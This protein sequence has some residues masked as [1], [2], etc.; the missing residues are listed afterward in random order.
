VTRVLILLVAAKLLFHAWYVPAWEGPDEPFHLARV[1]G[2]DFVSAN[3]VHSIQTHPCAS[4]LHRAVGCSPFGSEAGGKPQPLQVRN[5]EAHQPPL[6]YAIGRVWIA[7]FNDPLSQLCAM[8]LFSSLLVIAAIVVFL[9]PIG[10]GWLDAALLAMLVPGAAEALARCANDAG[11]FAWSAAAMWAISRKVRTAFI[12]VLAM[13]GPLVKLTALVVVA[14]LIAW[15]YENRD[16]IHAILIASLSMLFIPLQQTRGYRFGGTVEL[17]AAAASTHDSLSQWV[18]GF[19]RSA[20]TFLKTAFWLGEW[21]FFRAPVWLLLLVAM[22]AILFLASIRFRSD[23]AMPHAVALAVAIFASA[24]FFVS[25]RH[26]WGQWGGV[27]GWYAW[28]W[29]P[30]IAIAIR[31]VTTLRHSRALWIAGAALATIANL[32]W[33]VAAQRIYA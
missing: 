29:F 12:A 15:V 23:R 28:G 32:A 27:G 30:W 18:F 19:A 20:Y 31:D 22:F 3:I 26:Y 8:R 24:A 6:F 2:G 13:L 1:R 14:F 9:R 7:P 5:Y 4:D 33:F 17:N 21:S 10:A 11:V 16:A 25:H